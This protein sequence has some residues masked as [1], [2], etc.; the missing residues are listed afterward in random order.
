MSNN[1]F[2]YLR[3]AE[4]K[5]DTRGGISNW[6]LSERGHK[7]AEAL[8]NEEIFSDIDE[9]ITSGEN[10]AVQTALPLAKKLEIHIKQ[11][12]ELNELYRDEEE[13][14]TGVDYR[15]YVNKTLSNIHKPV[16]KWETGIDALTRFAKKMDEIDSEYSDMKILVVSHGLVINLYFCK[17]L[18]RFEDAFRRWTLTTF[19]DY[20]IVKNA[21]VIE[22]IVIE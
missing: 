2:Y 20:G 18:E 6:V 14:L 11:Y 22:D 17:L 7:Q 9:I 13:F 21:K 19:C 16:G 15:K 8:V 4:T 5:I 1:V 3:H 10:K 12:A